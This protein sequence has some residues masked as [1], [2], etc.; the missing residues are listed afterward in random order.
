MPASGA[1]NIELEMKMKMRIRIKAIK[2][3]CLELKGTSMVIKMWFV[4]DG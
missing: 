1:R 4:E 3:V 2:S